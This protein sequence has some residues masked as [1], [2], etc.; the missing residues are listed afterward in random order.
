[1]QNY[2]PFSKLD[3]DRFGPDE[4]RRL[5]SDREQPIQLFARLLKK[6]PPAPILMFHGVGGIGKTYLMRYLMY[7]YGFL[8]KSTIIGYPHAFLS[9]RSGHTSTSTERALWQV[10]EQL[11]RVKKRF[12]FPRFDLIWGKLWERSYQIPL[13]QNKELLP[14]EVNWICELLQSCELIPIIGDAAKG[15]KLLERLTQ[16]V[17]NVISVHGVLDWFRERVEIPIGL[18]WKVALQSMDLQDLTDLLPAAFAADLADIA[19]NMEPPFNRVVIF[20][21]NYETLQ[22]QLGE[23]F[24]RESTNFIEA[25]AKE[26][27][28]VKANTLVIIAGRDRLRWAEV[29]QRDGT[30]ILDP[31]SIWAQEVTHRD[32]HVYSSRFLE[33]YS[34]GDLSEAD[35]RQYLLERHQLTDPGQVS[36]I[37]KFTGGFPLALGVAAD[38]IGEVGKQVPFDFNT[39]RLRVSEHA[40]LSTKWRE[41]V[42]D[43]L[44]ERLIEQLKY[45]HDDSLV[46]LTQAAAIPR[47]F[48]RELL[49]SLLPYPWISEQFRRLVSYSFVEPYEVAGIQGFRLHSVTRKLLLQDIDLD[50]LREQWEKAAASWFETQG[51]KSPGKGKWRYQFEVLYHL[52]RLNPVE[53]VQKLDVWFNELVSVGEHELCW[54]LLETASEYENELPI[55]DQIRLNLYKH[56]L[57][58]EEWY[59]KGT[60][61]EF[62]LKYS[63]EAVRLAKNHTDLKLMSDACMAHAWSLVLMA[64]GI[65][66]DSRHYISRAIEMYRCAYEAA[67]SSGD[68]SRIAFA[69]VSRATLETDLNPNYGDF[70]FLDRAIELYQQN[71]DIRGQRD[72][73]FAK[74]VLAL[75]LEQWEHIDPALT[76]AVDLNQHLL[77]HDV[78]W[79][80]HAY[81][82]WGEY[83]TQCQQWERASDYLR[84]AKGIYESLY[85]M[86]GICAATGWLG[87][88]QCHSGDMAN[89]ISLVREALRIEH[90]TLGSQEGVAKWLHY[91]GD[92]FMGCNQYKRALACLWLSE[93]LREALSHSEIRKTTE[94]I[95]EIEITLG[96]DLFEQ[97]KNKFLPIKSEFGEYAFLWGFD[98]FRKHEGN[99]ILAPSDTYWEANAIYNPAGWTDGEK[100]FLLYR[101]EGTCNFPGRAF[102]SRIGLA[103][104][105]DGIYFKR[106]PYPIMEP[107]EAYEIPGGCEDPR[108]VRI[109][110]TFYMTYTAYDGKVARLSMAMSKDLYSWTKLGPL[111]PDDIWEK[112]FASDEYRHLFPRGWSKSG[113]ILDQKVNG[114]YWMYFG[115]THIWVANSRDLRKWDVVQGPVLSPRSGLFDAHLV[116]PGPPPRMYPEGIW[117]GYNGA[118]LNLR[119]SFGQALFAADNPTKLIRRCTRPLLEPTNEFEIMGQVP[120]VVFGEGLVNFQGKWLLYYGMADSR[121]GVVC[122]TNDPSVD[123]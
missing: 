118:D 32:A 6:S 111:F 37:Y 11:K 10:R 105:D 110:D 59:D 30:W 72:A 40:P 31:T 103:V 62:A 33:Q 89:G 76:K 64:F 17:R 51:G 15:L 21:D 42:N 29:R 5:F 48:N 38:L 57:E 45:K 60:N 70:S 81:Q 82:M 43:W 65:S 19:S 109:D 24:G 34:I 54:E 113:A 114:Y 108:L 28:E 4:L 121:V 88:V 50:E 18:G 14:D 86:G 16:R 123:K 46:S 115:D 84:K 56:T 71:D 9:F 74:A 63:E 7:E 100:V 85:F 55:S 107:T 102:T 116:E 122:A 73:H 97:Y 120:K 44:L 53:A 75:R 101:A 68:S 95:H 49:Y 41:E 78:L 104:S 92:M 98:S 58:K 66:V 25:L 77:P 106:E 22:E 96:K 99:P 2:S 12:T 67:E 47:W 3:R 39:L 80:G 93:S 91:L 119:Y 27:V 26:L 79:K 90:D 94:K 20:V 87:I 23:S 69:L 112:I 35:A 52:W 83:Y 117:L 61:R 13:S 8:W 1:M 36:E